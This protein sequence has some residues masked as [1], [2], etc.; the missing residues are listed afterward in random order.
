MTPATLVPTKLRT[1]DPWQWTTKPVE[2]STP[3]DSTRILNSMAI[4]NVRWI[5]FSHPPLGKIPLLD[6]FNSSYWVDVR[7]LGDEIVVCVMDLSF[8]L[9]GKYVR[10][11]FK[12]YIQEKSRTLSHAP[13]MVYL[14]T[15]W[16]ILF[17]QMIVNIPAT[18]SIYANHVNPVPN[19]ENIH[20]A[21]E[22]SR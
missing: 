10:Y 9:R 1:W 8:V 13:G 15:F 5:C 12:L 19:P 18:R 3:Q 14:P 4:L 20:K 2:L 21:K 7:T 11:S 17:G 22:M 6:C 16:V